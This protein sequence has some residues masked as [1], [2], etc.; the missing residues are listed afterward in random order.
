MN[1]SLIILFIL[2]PL[3]MFI[4]N[5]NS[6]NNSAYSDHHQSSVTNPSTHHLIQQQY[7]QQ[8]QQHYSYHH[9]P[10]HHHLQ[11]TSS[12]SNYQQNHLN[13]Q[14]LHQDA[15]ISTTT[16]N[17][18]GSTGLNQSNIKSKRLCDVNEK[19][20]F[21]IFELLRRILAYSSVLRRIGM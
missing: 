14:H 5:N 6:N 3:K 21:L 16:A 9:Q 10:S 2:F 7:Q 17:I 19:F 1:Y 18:Y 8:Q 11:G 4:P 15:S 13:Y 20:V 12:S